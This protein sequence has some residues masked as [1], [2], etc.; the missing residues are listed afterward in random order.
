MA[1]STLTANKNFLQPTGFRVSIDNTLFGN[2]QFFAQ[3]VSHPGASTNAVEVAT[4]R[5]TGIP[6][7]GSKITYS[8]L[9]VNLILDEDMQSYTELQKWMERL[10]NE[11]EVRP[12]DRYRG[13][14]EKDETY[15]D[16]TVTILTSQ[17]NSNLRIR[18]N[19][20][21]I[22]NLGSFELNANAN[23]ITYIQFPAT[24]RFRD[25]EIVKL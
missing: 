22:T 8:D 16:I 11:K 23:D 10:V 9:T 19:D 2:V 12:G 14:V 25:F 21:I 3:S 4:P 20:A 17:N 7:S 6:F 1:K 24:F 15:S 5:V 18:Y 13:Q